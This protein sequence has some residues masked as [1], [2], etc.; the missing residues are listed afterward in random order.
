MLFDIHNIK[1]P[2]N[3]S[4]D[5]LKSLTA[6][7][8]SVPEE[9]IRNIQIIKESLDARN[10]SSINFIYT[11][12]ADL[13]TD[14]FSSNSDFIPVESAVTPPLVPGS[15]NI[16]NRP[17]II[18][19]GP[20]GLFAGF[21]LAE[22]G[23]NPIILERGEDVDNRTVSVK[24]YWEEG[25]L[26]PES[27]VQFG[28]GGA[29]TFSDGKLTTRIND[30]RCAK[31]LD[32]MRQSGI[33]EHILYK[34]KPHI[35]TDKLKDF[36]RYIRSRIV[37][38]GGEIR[39]LSKVTDITISDGEVKN[40]IVNNIEKIETSIVI[41]SIGHS[42]RD[43]FEML[44]GKNILI[45]QKAFSIGVRIEH[46]QELINRSQFGNYAG[47]K[48]LGAAE[49]QLFKKIGDRTVYSFCMC[50]GGIVAASASEENSIVTNGMSEYARDR[51]NANSAL[52]VS[53]EPSDF[54]SLNPLAGMYFQRKIEQN[55]FK[56]YNG[57]APVQRV[58]DFFKDRRSKFL[59]DV[60]PSYTG[61]TSL[62]N[63][64]DVLPE[65]VINGLKKGIIQFNSMLKG[66]SFPDAL[67]TGV[68]TRTSSPLRIERDEKFEAV[69]IKGLY[70]AGEGAGYAGGIMSAAVDG[71]RVSEEVIKQF[72]PA[73]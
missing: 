43:T 20:A 57:Y 22:Y 12:R 51:E 13:K 4:I 39:F 50:P 34:A 67:L 65:Y 21:Q 52:V 2:L 48:E 31:V 35:G 58:E 24:K 36:L 5:S 3:L 8:L 6:S 16:I 26:N 47:H 72:K 30:K 14:F 38:Y 15:K 70:P 17:V 49:Y 61:E 25:I 10:K 23:F 64:S 73:M 62:G 29:G 11:V 59:G 37:E 63:I 68:E 33:E 7:K 9:E 1:R 41:L 46:P 66:F 56:C 71:L 42:A 28:E 55:T 53:V 27:N 44:Y 60:K 32:V 69:G 40:V 45:K 18:G 54:G 19:S